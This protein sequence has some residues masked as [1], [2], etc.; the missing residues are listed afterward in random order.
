MLLSSA[1]AGAGEPLRLAVASNF[2]A[3]MQAIVERYQTETGRT[4]LISPGSTGKHYAQI[5]NGAPFD[6]FFAADSERP[7]RLEAEE[8]AVAGS[9]FT[10]A[11]GRLVLWSSAPGRVLPGGQVLSSGD[12]RRLALA[13][14]KLAPYGRAAREVLESLDLWQA[15]APRLVRGENI[16]QTFQ[17]VKTGAA[18]LGFIAASQLDRGA[19]ACAGRDC[20]LVPASLYSPIDQQVVLLKDNAAARDF[21]AFIQREETRRLIRSFGY[22]VPVPSL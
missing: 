18:E 19:E 9:R 15:L 10:Y 6:L 5:L 2:S 22:E 12:F 4:L 7:A 17:F 8:I 21:L 3:A 13:N 14:P 1:V 11:R 20:W 16:A